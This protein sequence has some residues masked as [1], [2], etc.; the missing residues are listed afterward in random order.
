MARASYRMSVDDETPRDSVVYPIAASIPR[1]KLDAEA[2]LLTHMSGQPFWKRLPT[3]LRL[4]GPGFLGA[5]LTLGAGTLTAAMLSGA[6]FGY[7]T[8]WISWVTIGNGIFMMSAIARFTT[9]GQFRVIDVQTSKHGW[10]V[11]KILTAFLGLVCVS[12]CGRLLLCKTV[13]RRF[14]AMVG[15]SHVSGLFVAAP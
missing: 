3:Y 15:C 12:M 13:S 1:E 7:K 14:G 11:G 5:A 4:V 2:R 8:L 9:K 10:F 6:Q